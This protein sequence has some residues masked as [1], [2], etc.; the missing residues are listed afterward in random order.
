MAK[1]RCDSLYDLWPVS[2]RRSSSAAPWFVF[3]AMAAALVYGTLAIFVFDSGLMRYAS[4][5][6]M[7]VNR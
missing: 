1:T 6:R 3:K 7:V 4:G 2:T 5:N